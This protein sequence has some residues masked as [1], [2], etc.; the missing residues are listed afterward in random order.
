M[1]CWR[2]LKNV[3]ATLSALESHKVHALLPFSVPFA[4]NSLN[5][6]SV[7]DAYLVAEF[8]SH[9]LALV[10]QMILL[11]HTHTRARAYNDSCIAMHVC[12]HVTLCVYVCV[13]IQIMWVV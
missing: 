3:N 9:T 7:Y 5:E 8:F 13:Y 2:A 6:F 12:M 4:R 1:S 10:A 11:A